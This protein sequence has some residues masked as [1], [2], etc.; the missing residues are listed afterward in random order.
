MRA[1]TLAILLAG[2]LTVPSAGQTL[3]E[4]PQQGVQTEES[5]AFLFARARAADLDRARP[6]LDQI[7]P[8]AA[9]R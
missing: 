5:R 2:V 6:L 7:M 9:A 4:R 3:T 1:A 8:S